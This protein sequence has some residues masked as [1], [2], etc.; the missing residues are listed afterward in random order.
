[1]H[2]KRGKCKGKLWRQNSRPNYEV[3]VTIIICICL[4]TEMAVKFQEQRELLYNLLEQGWVHARIAMHD[5]NH[6]VYTS[7]IARLVPQL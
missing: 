7:S 1:M 3:G 6:D 4:N 2:G 5:H